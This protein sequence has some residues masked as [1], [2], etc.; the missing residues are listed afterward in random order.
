MWENRNKGRQTRNI[1]F[2]KTCLFAGRP[3]KLEAIMNVINKPPK[4]RLKKFIK[5]KN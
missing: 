4:R 1:D 5:K 2:G 3:P